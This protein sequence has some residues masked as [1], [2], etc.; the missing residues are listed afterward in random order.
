MGLSIAGL[1]F[2]T[3][4][5][6]TPADYIARLTGMEPV[7]VTGDSQFDTRDAGSFRVETDGETVLIINADLGLNTFRSSSQQ[8]QQIYH[9]LDMPEEIIAFAVLESGGTY[10]YAILH[11]GVLVRA[12]L[13]ESGD[14]PPSIDTGTPPAIEQ[15]WLDCPFYLLYDGDEADDDLVMDEEELDEVEIEKVYYKGDRED[16]LLECL[17]T[18]KVVEELFEDR[19][20]FTPWNTSEL[21]EVFEF[22][23]PAATH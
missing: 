8:L 13:Q 15:A 18:E 16:E 19:F 1:A 22:K 23:L 5:E 12:R 11:Q 14:F 9:A 7:A 2:K 21:E 20:G 17:L 10:G 3:Q 6:I 4:K